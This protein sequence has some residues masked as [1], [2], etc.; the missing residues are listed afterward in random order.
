MAAACSQSLLVLVTAS[1]LTK[2]SLV[3]VRE[4]IS[5]AKACTNC[6]HCLLKFGSRSQFLGL[7]AHKIALGGFF[8]SLISG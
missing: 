3:N 7:F 5:L 6:Y 8:S 2:L 4:T 1:T